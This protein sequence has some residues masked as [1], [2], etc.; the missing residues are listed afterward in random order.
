G[1]DRNRSADPS[2]VA[3]DT[4]R[5]SGVRCR[6]LKLIVLRIGLMRPRFVGPK[7]DGQKADFLVKKII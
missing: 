4:G 3:C 5:E 2:F 7:K 1:W 6:R